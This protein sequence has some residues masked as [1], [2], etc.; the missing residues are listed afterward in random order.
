M[1]AQEIGGEIGERVEEGLNAGRRNVLIV[2][3]MNQREG[4]VFMI[5]LP[6]PVDVFAGKPGVG[7]A[8][9]QRPRDH[10]P[11]LV[12]SARSRWINGDSGSR[13]ATGDKT[14]KLIKIE[15]TRPPSGYYYGGPVKKL[16][17]LR[18]AGNRRRGNRD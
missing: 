8:R 14:G 7:G 10:G 13:F 2:S 9:R 4:I 12:V 11:C 3:S 17:A 1:M 15:D 16:F 5:V 18:C 6:I